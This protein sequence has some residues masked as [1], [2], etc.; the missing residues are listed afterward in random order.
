MKSLLKSK[1]I[2]TAEK[3]SKINFNG[4]VFE[5]GV[6]SGNSINHISEQIKSE[7]YGFDLFEG[8]PEF[9]RDGF[10]KGHFSMK[11]LPKVNNKVNLVKGWFNET[12]P[13]FLKDHQD[14]ISFLHI[15]CDLY[16]ST[17][18]IFDNVKNQLKVGTVIVFDEYFNYPGWQL[19]EFKA[20]QE[21]VV[22]ESIKYQYIG[23]NKYHEQVALQ[24]TSIN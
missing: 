1:I 17:K 10:D 16:S 5:F 9:W 6:F 22:E 8:L 12:L 20:W 21:L 23:Y 15:D 19:G 14:D 7:I 4:I 2:R 3:L 13:I 18:T 24:I 11:K